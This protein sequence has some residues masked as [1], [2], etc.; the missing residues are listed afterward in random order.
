MSIKC[1][2]CGAENAD[3]ALFCQQCGAPMGFRAP[4]A[5]QPM[6]ETQAGKTSSESPSPSPSPYAAPRA[7]N[8]ARE[9]PTADVFGGFWRRFAAAIIDGIILNVAFYAVIIAV[10]GVASAAA[11]EEVAGALAIGVY[12][13]SFVANW[14]YFALME[15][16][17]ARATVG[18]M[19]LGI[20]VT[21]EAGE[22]IGFGKATGRYFGK[23]ISSFILGIGFL[24]AAWTRK[25]QGLH[26]M[27]AGTLV[28][29]KSADPATIASGAIAPPA[30][31]GEIA[32]VIVAACFVFA[33]PVIG[34]LAAIAI[35]Q[36]QT[37]TVRAK[38]TQAYYLA[39][40]AQEAVST[41]YAE[42]EAVPA[43][44]ADAGFVT[45]LSP[46]I[47]DITIDAEGVI[48]VNL[49]IPSL[50]GN[51]LLFIPEANDG[52][53]LAWTCRSEDVSQKFLLP[54]CKG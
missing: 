48:S 38:V 10:V 29:R 28:V 43:T 23:I 46:H 3:T 51:S 31:G 53:K 47:S 1:Q 49:A 15:A 18:K 39:K 4:T 36:Y 6:V 32:G 35:P 13:L 2:K 14:L 34:I 16:S 26:D 42:N 27:M 8:T 41:Y 44:L 21:D 7:A 5:R 30:S 33:L 22:R 37:Y 54:T 52:K 50:E 40:P 45:P 9:V 11:S 20:V 17:G 19:A 12:L 24:M 25:R